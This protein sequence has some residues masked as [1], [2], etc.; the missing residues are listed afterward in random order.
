M[1]RLLG[2]VDDPPATVVGAATGVDESAVDGGVE[3]DTDCGA[4]V[5]VAPAPAPP[6]CPEL[7][8]CE[9]PHAAVATSGITT[10]RARQYGCFTSPTLRR[11]VDQFLAWAPDLRGIGA[12]KDVVVLLHHDVG[13][14]LEVTIDDVDR[15]V[16]VHGRHDAD[17]VG[18]ASADVSR[19]I[20][21]DGITHLGRASVGGQRLAVLY[22]PRIK[23]GGFRVK[24]RKPRGEAGGD[25]YE[26]GEVGT[27]LLAG[28]LHPEAGVDP[29]RR[30]AQARIENGG[31]RIAVEAERHAGGVV[32]H[33]VLAHRNGRGAIA[34]G[35]FRGRRIPRT[36]AQV[37]R[38]RRPGA[39]WSEPL[40]TGRLPVEPQR[41][42]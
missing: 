21:H 36:G 28:V 6:W 15:P 22:A 30:R 19:G 9:G 17:V 4:E 40:R 18:I 25:P 11:H 42:G 12:G 13:P 33:A 26:L 41:V 31:V 5:V 23:T 29:A 20:E 16:R 3:V 39:E 27:P 35:R 2:D 32:A 34:D 37:R 24:G 7:D 10:T 1:V 8:T 38:A 14:V